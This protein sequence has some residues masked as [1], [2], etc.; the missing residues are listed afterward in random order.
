MDAEEPP[1]DGPPINDNA[2]ELAADGPPIN[3][4]AQDVEE[5]DAEGVPAQNGEEGDDGEFEDEEFDDDEEI[6]WEGV[7]DAD[8]SGWDEGMRL[9]IERGDPEITSLTIRDQERLSHDGMGGMYIA[10][11]DLSDFI[12]NWE[13]DGAAIGNNTHLRELHFSCLHQLGGNPG[14][15]TDEQLATFFSSLAASSQNSRIQSM[16]F[17]LSDLR[18]VAFHNLGDFF[19]NR[20]DFERLRILGIWGSP[21]KIPALNAVGLDRLRNALGQFSSLVEF[22]LS[23]SSLNDEEAESLINALGKHSRLTALNLRKNYL[24][25]KACSALASNIGQRNNV[26]LSKLVL[27]HNTLCDEGL[28]T[29]GGSLADSTTLTEL[30]L[31][32]NPGV[33]ARGWKPI[34]D[35]LQ[36][37]LSNLEELSLSQNTIDD[38][39]AM[40]LSGH[41]HGNSKMKTLNMGSCHQITIKGWRAL[42]GAM[43]GCALENLKVHDN[44]TAGRSRRL[45][46]SFGDDAMLALS[47][48]LVGNSSLRTLDL[49]GNRG[50]TAQGWRAFSQCLQHPESALEELFTYTP[51]GLPDIND[52]SATLLAQSLSNNSKLKVLLLGYASLS[53]KMVFRVQ[54]TVWATLA[55]L[56]C[57]KASILDTYNSNHTLQKL[58][59]ASDEI[60]TQDSDI[61]YRDNIH[62]FL[63]MNEAYTRCEAARRKV[64]VA[65][66]GGDIVPHFMQMERKMLPHAIAWM[67]KE[68]HSDADSSKKNG[69]PSLHQFVQKVLFAVDLWKETSN[70]GGKRQRLN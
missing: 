58:F 2:Q 60:G 13:S 40:L 6:E 4:N 27:S 47:D 61:E 44:Q 10:P 64:I 34:L 5:L 35:L 55:Q 19:R 49:S 31:S 46:S 62:P 21:E 33:S 8:N 38:G 51:G 29:L 54:G 24:G 56:L 36:N 32:N 25:K 1:A 53:A 43:Q 12:P 7:P 52:D 48:A 14:D 66:F 65:H 63:Q 30:H 42:F 20:D 23:E 3:A 9:R 17:N 11:R 26:I 15:V 22:E 16:V 59:T 67:A 18:G 39:C 45:C 41:L 28:A 68:C 37:P 69:L 70:G 50:I 57:N